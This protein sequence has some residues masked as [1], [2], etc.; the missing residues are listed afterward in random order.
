MGV[1]YD[2]AAANCVRFE[3]ELRF[4][5]VAPVTPPCRHHS[6]D[7]SDAESALSDQGFDFDEGLVRSPVVAVGK[8]D[9]ISG[10]FDDHLFD[11]AV[12]ASVRTKI[13]ESDCSD[14]SDVASFD[15]DEHL[16]KQ[17]HTEAFAA[18]SADSHLPQGD[19]DVGRLDNYGQVSHFWNRC[20]AQTFGTMMRKLDQKGK[21]LAAR[22]VRGNH[23]GTRTYANV[24]R[25]AL[26]RRRPR[27]EFGDGGVY[28][29]YP[30]AQRAVS[31]CVDVAA[32][33]FL[34]DLFS[35]YQCGRPLAGESMLLVSN[36]YDGTTFPV[37]LGKCEI[38]P[39]DAATVG[40]SAHGQIFV[41]RGHRSLVKDIAGS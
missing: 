30:D 35:S 7:V 19:E 17:Q 12:D 9:N 2:A 5:F 22:E 16:R 28:R 24:C 39:L 32:S 41:H 33:R 31:E 26:L 34:F 29:H 23:P 6:P 27:R 37:R 40:G 21:R 13:V 25:T 18:S 3:E 38:A 10:D 8:C 15:F 14:L 36:D 20:V 1:H 11:A 4:A